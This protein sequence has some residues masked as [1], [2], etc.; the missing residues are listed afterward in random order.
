MAILFHS[1]WLD[2]LSIERSSRVNHAGAFVSILLQGIEPTDEIRKNSKALGTFSD[3]VDHIDLIIRVAG[4]HHVGIHHVG[5]QSD[6]DGAPPLP[7]GLDDVLTYPRFTQDLLNRGSKRVAIHKV[8]GGN[9]RRVLR[10]AEKVASSRRA[11]D[12]TESR[13]VRL[14]T[15]LGELLVFP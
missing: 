12:V 8:L 5:I 14:K 9:I 4:I 13:I 6:F 10:E 3:V 7:V 2:R 15:A 11:S 1:L